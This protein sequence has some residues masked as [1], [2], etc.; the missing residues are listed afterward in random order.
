MYIALPK[1]RVTKC[2]PLG[3]GILALVTYL[4]SG[5]LGPH[6]TAA[7]RRRNSW[8]GPIEQ[9]PLW[10]QTGPDARRIHCHIWMRRVTLKFYFRFTCFRPLSASAWSATCD[11]F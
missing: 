3:V 7:T 5:C 4:G 6:W 10:R 11:A 1:N 8:W 2:P 9:S